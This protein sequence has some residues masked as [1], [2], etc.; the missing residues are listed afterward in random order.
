MSA[1]GNLI[2][3][4][5]EEFRLTY[6]DALQQKTSDRQLLRRSIRWPVRVGL[7]LIL[8]LCGGFLLFGFVV[9]IAG[10]AVAVGVVNPNGSR[11][12]VQHL[13][14]G[15]V[16]ELRVQDGDKVAAGQVLVIVENEQ[17]RASYDSLT[18]QRWALLA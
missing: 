13:E 12:T 4:R 16:A 8:V 5:S 17:E 1:D 9:K 3:P 7:A 18:M 11:K 2:I 10:G 14:G 6:L 15:I